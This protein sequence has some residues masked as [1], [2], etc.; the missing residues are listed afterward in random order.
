MSA[1][2]WATCDEPSRLFSYLRSSKR[3]RPTSRQLLLFAAACC[4]RLE[5]LFEW[6]WERPTL[7]VLERML[8]GAATADELK[9]VQESCADIHIWGGGNLT[10]TERVFLLIG[11][12][13][14]DQGKTF[15]ILQANAVADQTATA[16][17]LRAADQSTTFQLARARAETEHAGNPIGRVFVVEVARAEAMAGPLALEKQAQCH[18]LR[19]VLGNPFRPPTAMVTQSLRGVSTIQQLSRG[20]HDERAFERLPILADALEE[21]GCTDADILAHLRGPG[22]HVRGCWVLD[23]ILGRS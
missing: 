21:A 13:F 20:I 4:R 7:E 14:R 15:G 12:A 5:H 1:E 2:T 8:E 11:T 9:A 22:P 19:D 6:D 16:V 17:G 10:P 3:A 23:L 18:L